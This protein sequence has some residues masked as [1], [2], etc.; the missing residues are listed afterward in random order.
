MSGNLIARSVHDLSAATWF[1][2]S[3]MGAI[4]LNGAASKAA[5]T[6]ERTLL[7]SYGWKKWAPV[8]AA[9]F[10][11]HLASL[12]P[13]LVD[14]KA[15]YAGQEGVMRWTWIKAGVTVTGAALTL[16]AGLL[17]R[18]VGQLAE[19]GAE[20]ATEPGP[21]SSPELAKAQNQLKFLQWIIPVFAGAVVVLGAWH[22]EMQRPKNVK[23]GF[24]QRLHLV[25]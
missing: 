7:S 24:L 3:L 17:G 9:A 23:L 6:T 1:G 18:K 5:N 21:S 10:G 12:G 11:A 15:R 13:I 16:Y 20:G 4:G 8:Q 2:G 25:A 14:N 19:E 22:G